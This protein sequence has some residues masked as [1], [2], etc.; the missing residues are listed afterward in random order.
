MKRTCKESEYI[1]VIARRLNCGEPSPIGLGFMSVKPDLICNG[2]AYEVECADKVHYGVGQA[3][4]YQYGGL[5][6]GLIVIV[7]DED[8][9]RTVQLVNFLRWVSTKLGI[10]VRILKCAGYDCEML[11]IV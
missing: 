4:A 11:R 9:N 5:Q 2:V 8:S 3:L 7:S 6:A 1:A 10:D